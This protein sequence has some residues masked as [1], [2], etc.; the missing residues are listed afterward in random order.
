MLHT[1]LFPQGIHAV[2]A[3]N[4]LLAVYDHLVR[5]FPE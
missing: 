3:G 5:D 2:L 1:H 4:A